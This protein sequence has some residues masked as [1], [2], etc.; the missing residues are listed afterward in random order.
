MRYKL[1]ALFGLFLVGYIGG[2]A[3]TSGSVFVSQVGAEMPVDVGRSM[4]PGISVPLTT[5]LGMGS[6]GERVMLQSML[7]AEGRLTMI[8]ISIAEC[9]FEQG[10]S[11]LAETLNAG[12]RRISQ[13]VLVMPA[14]AMVRDASDRSDVIHLVALEAP[15]S[16]IPHVPGLVCTRDRLTSPPR[17]VSE[18]G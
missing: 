5:V 9:G 1:L 2:T 10:Q 6:D 11:R 7:P 15:D 12:D 18:A 8:L 13:T 3:A 4:A 17:E 16:A 14:A